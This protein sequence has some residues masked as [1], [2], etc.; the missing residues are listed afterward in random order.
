VIQVRSPVLTYWKGQIYDEFD[1]SGWRVD[2]AFQL[3]RQNGNDSVLFQATQTG[4]Q[5]I[6]PLYPQTFFMFDEPA[7]GAIFTGYAPLSMVVPSNDEGTPKL[8]DGSSCH[9]ISTFPDFSRDALDRARANSR[10]NNRYHEVLEHMIDLPLLATE[11]TGLATQT[12][13]KPSVLSAIWT[14]TT[15][16]TWGRR[17]SFSSALTRWNF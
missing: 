10:L 16:S 15:N 13:H 8:E 14:S 2:N 6:E 4:K 17:T 11:I 12:C 1:G 3:V 9:V 7:K 5:P